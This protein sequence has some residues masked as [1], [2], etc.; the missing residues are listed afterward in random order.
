M[1]CPS[2]IPFRSHENP[3]RLSLFSSHLLMDYA[4]LYL[5]LFFS[6]SIASFQFFFSFIFYIFTLTNPLPLP[7]P[8][9]CFFI[10]KKYIIHCPFSSCFP[11]FAHEIKDFSSPFLTCHLCVP[12]LSPLFWGA[13]KAEMGLKDGEVGSNKYGGRG[14]EWICECEYVEYE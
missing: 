8:I 10:S 14:V 6:D 4:F 13:R 11:L 3:S 1:G 5:I 9:Q 12:D 2:T 7:V